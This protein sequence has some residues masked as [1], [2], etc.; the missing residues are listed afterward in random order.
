MSGWIKQAGGVFRRRQGLYVKQSGAVPPA[1]ITLRP[2][3]AA[4][5]YGA[6]YVAAYPTALE[7]GGTFDPATAGAS[8]TL[9]GGDLTVTFTGT[10]SVGTT[11]LIPINFTSDMWCWEVLYSAGNWSAAGS[12]SDSSGIP[13]DGNA[14][15]GGQPGDSI[16]YNDNGNVTGYVPAV[17]PGPAAVAGDIFGFVQGDGASGNTALLHVFINGVEVGSG[18]ANPVGATQYTPTVTQA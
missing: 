8:V 16:C 13:F 11:N 5:T 14:F 18:Y 3:F 6:A 7:L 9:S 17:T 15:M 10:G 2:T 12:F 1:S 4:M